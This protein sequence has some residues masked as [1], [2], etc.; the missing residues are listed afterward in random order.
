LG[1]AGC[2]NRDEIRRYQVPKTAAPTV[3]PNRDAMTLD[4]SAPHAVAPEAD[5]MLGAIIPQGQQAWFFK[6]TGPKEALAPH[7]EAFRALIR[8]VRFASGQPQWQLPDGWRQQRG[9][10]MRFATLEVGPADK[11]LPLTVIALPIPA[12]GEA[13]S[14][15]SNVNRWR[16]QLRLPPISPAQL[17]KESEQIQL[18]GAVATVVD[19]EGS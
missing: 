13:A 8:S 9:S 19:L 3:T 11:P 17:P 12:D 10:G 5:R 18:E 16:G 1:L 14:V 2:E 6:L 4:S 15:L 7:V